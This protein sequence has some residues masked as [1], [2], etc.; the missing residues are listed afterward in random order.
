MKISL[1]YSLKIS[2][3]STLI[4]CC[5]SE[6]A[7]AGKYKDILNSLLDD[8]Q[9]ICEGSNVFWRI[10]NET[11]QLIYPVFNEEIDKIKETASQDASVLSIQKLREKAGDE[12]KANKAARPKEGQYQGYSQRGDRNAK[13]I[14]RIP[15]SACSNLG[16]EQTDRRG[17]G[18]SL[19]SGREITELRKKN[20]GM[21]N[22][23][24]KQQ[25]TITGQKITIQDLS[26]ELSRKDKAP[27]ID[28]PDDIEK[29]KRENLLLQENL[30]QERQAK[31]EALI[32]LS[33]IG[34]ERVRNNNPNIS[35]LSDPNRPIKIAEQFSELYDNLWTE[36]CDALE[37]VYG[38]GDEKAIIQYLL[39]ML[40]AAYSI[41]HKIMENKSKELGKVLN[42]DFPTDM[43]QLKKPVKDFIRQYMG[44]PDDND[45]E[46]ALLAFNKMLRTHQLEVNGCLIEEFDVKKF[47]DIYFGDKGKSVLDILRS[48]ETVCLKLCRHMA[49][50]DPQVVLDF[51]L[52]PDGHFDTEKFRYYTENGSYCSF[53]VWPAMRLHQEGSYLSKGVAQGTDRRPPEKLKLKF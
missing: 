22:M 3:L 53:V 24:D 30:K 12:E 2:V 51:R 8:R 45:M 21:Q 47:Q 50:Q 6:V 18:V 9:Y 4:V 27:L 31:E 14:A 40:N 23:L 38:Q 20:Y 29:L 26:G 5:F 52:L 35:D 15:F 43:S 36:A 10:N 42:H 13:P 7:V 49:K 41:E 11:Q 34:S 39:L 32:R 37:E 1:F 28:V 48:Y 44:D 17:N 19:P 16:N 25:P 33:A 46:S